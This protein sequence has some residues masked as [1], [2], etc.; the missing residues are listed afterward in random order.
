MGIH[1]LTGNLPLELSIGAGVFLILAGVI[2]MGKGD[3]LI[4]GYN[5]A[6]AEKKANY[7]IQKIRCLVSI[8]LVVAAAL[9]L[10]LIPS[11]GNNTLVNIFIAVFLCITLVCIILANTWA[12]KK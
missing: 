3:F 1:T 12:K 6:G 7:N 2:G 9:L 11:A 5:T 8:I 10:G 4:A